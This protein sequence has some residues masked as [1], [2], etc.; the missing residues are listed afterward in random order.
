MGFDRRCWLHRS[1]TLN[2]RRNRGI[3]NE[4]AFRVVAER[5]KQFIWWGRT[6]KPV[7]KEKDQEKNKNAFKAPKLNPSQRTGNFGGQ[8]Q[9]K[10]WEAA[11]LEASKAMIDPGLSI[12]EVIFSHE[13]LGREE[14]PLL[15][16]GRG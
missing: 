8:T 3:W 7:E 2:W 5:E 15:E 14:E 11:T 4:F 16:G 10:E 9:P 12:I 13:S 6:R 1:V